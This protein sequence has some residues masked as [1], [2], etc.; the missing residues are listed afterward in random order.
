M[1]LELPRRTE[2]FGSVKINDVQRVLLL[3]SDSTEGDKKGETSVCS[4]PRDKI[5]EI[6]RKMAII[7]P[8]M[9]EKLNLIEG[10]MSAIPS[11][12]LIIIVSNSRRDGVDRFKMECEMVDQHIHYAKRGIWI[13]HQK[14][15]KIGSALKKVGY[16]EFLDKQGI[17][18]DGKAEGMILGMLVAKAAEK[19]Y[20]GFVDADN[21]IPGAVH[22]YVKIFSAAFYLSKSPYVMVRIAWSYKPKILEGSLYFSKWGRVSTITNRYLNNV[23]A[24]FSG[25][26][27]EV[28]KTGNSGD[29]AMTIKLAE[30]LNYRS[31]FAVEPSEIMSVLEQF[32][33]ISEPRFE[34]PME[35]GVDIFQMET[36]NPHFHDQKGDEHLEEMLSDALSTILLSPL[37][38]DYTRKKIYEE[39]PKD[40]LHL[41]TKGNS[42]KSF[43]HVDI[44]SF[45][46]SLIQDKA[47]LIFGERTERTK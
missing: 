11:E 15:P 13:L 29:H 19:D 20:V 42:I 16:A 39:F 40:Q 31:K 4:I 45:I 6:E 43:V 30:I 24:S 36:R 2:R 38:S 14:D 12:C 9:N 46:D 34:D 32:G 7:I 22:E 5:Q 35:K 28:I 10:V 47:V 44:K 25:F 27:T 21:Y 41:E 8:V 37:C 18:R 17:V 3:D 33:G 26:E 23:I 1:K